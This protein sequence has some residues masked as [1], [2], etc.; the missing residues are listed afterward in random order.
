MYTTSREAVDQ[1]FPT[2]RLLMQFKKLFSN[3]G[4]RY[5]ELNWSQSG[6]LFRIICITEKSMWGGCQYY[7]QI[8]TKKKGKWKFVC[9]YCRRWCNLGTPYDIWD[10]TAT[11]NL[12]SS[13]RK[14]SQRSQGGNDSR[15]SGGNCVK[16]VLLVE[17]LLQTQTG[18]V[19]LSQN[20]A[21]LY[22]I[23]RCC[24][25]KTMLILI[26]LNK[27]KTCWNTSNGRILIIHHTL[28]IYHRA[29]TACFLSWRKPWEIA[30][31]G[32]NM[33]WRKRLDIQKV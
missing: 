19:K 15:K 7:C 33:N 3:I 10:Q 6:E 20:F 30:A 5:F 9:L 12:V 11:Q 8:P 4:T 23:E 13:R 32:Q 25:F 21:L 24:C 28:Q 2:I 26:P 1:L 22:W 18:F 29:T 14:R 16:S 17:Y 31:L 27:E